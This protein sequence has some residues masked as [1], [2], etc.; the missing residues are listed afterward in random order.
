LVL[1]GS[2][3]LY[4]TTIRQVDAQAFPAKTQRSRKDP[5]PAAVAVG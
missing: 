3:S 5:E 1:L 2:R 4:Y